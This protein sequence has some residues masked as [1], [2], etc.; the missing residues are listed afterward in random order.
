MS[1]PI[2]VLLEA[3]AI[4]DPILSLEWSGT[5]CKGK[6]V[7]HAKAEK[8]CAALGAGWRLPTRPELESILDLTRHDPAIDTVR[9]RHTKSGC[10][11]TS[12]PYARS[13]DCA[14]IVSFDSGYSSYG[15]RGYSDAFV[16]AV[17]SVPAVTP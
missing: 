10:Y 14:W 8:A 15:R 11:W 4:R 9:F 7:N 2:D 13:S 6:R 5:L 12:T 17:R 16:R 1:A 3:T